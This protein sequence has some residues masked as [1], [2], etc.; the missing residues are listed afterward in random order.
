M[1]LQSNIKIRDIAGERLIVLQGKNGLDLTRVV[2]LNGTAEWLWNELQGTEF[3]EACA[4]AIL[5]RQ[6]G[7]EEEQALADARRWIGG[8]SAAGLI[9]E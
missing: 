6:Y 2:E 8:L 3:T 7:I 5:A 4:A 1:R 9:A